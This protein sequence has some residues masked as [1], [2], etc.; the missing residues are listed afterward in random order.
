[1][2]RTAALALLGA[3][4]V[5]GAFAV[6]DLGDLRLES[7]AYVALQGAMLAVCGLATM[8][9]WRGGRRRDLV[10]VIAVAVAA[11]AVLAFDA[12]TLSDDAYRFA[13]DGRVALEGVNPFRYAP[14]DPELRPL[15][16]F[17]VFVNVNR[18]FVNTIYPPTYQAVFAAAN[19]AGGDGVGP[20]KLAFLAAEGGL[21][22]L[23]LVLLART[24]RPAGRVVLY[25]WHPLAVLETASSAH[26]EALLMLLV[27]AAL[28]LW[29]RGRPAR[30]GVALGAAVLTKFVP[31]VLAPMLARRLRWRFALAGAATMALLYLPYLPAGRELFSAFGTYADESFGAG[32]YAWLA[33]TGVPEAAARGLPLAALAAAIAWTAARPP[34]DLAGAARASGLLLGGVLLASHNVAPWYGLWLLPFLCVAPVGGLLWLSATLPIYYLTVISNPVLEPDGVRLVV[35]GPTILL[36]ALEAVRSWGPAGAGARAAEEPARA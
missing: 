5:A 16:D 29:D 15:R 14:A 22:A 33:G 20:I 7:R 35:W 30:A 1:M 8:L 17:E 18:P 31:L 36:L 19:V 3:A 11:R 21:V 12:P 6:G 28:L 9:L 26:P 10:V 2:V 23:L 4:L 13:W 25:A 32:P 34:R 24:G 27:L